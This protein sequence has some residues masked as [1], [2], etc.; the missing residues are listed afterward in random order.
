MGMDAGITVVFLD[1][2][3]SKIY[4]EHVDCYQCRASGDTFS[5]PSRTDKVKV[6]FSTEYE[7]YSDSD[8]SDSDDE[9]FTTLDMSQIYTIC[10][11]E[12]ENNADK[13][14]YW[15]Q[16]ECK[17]MDWCNLLDEESKRLDKE[18]SEEK[19]FM[20]K[21]DAFED[22]VYDNYDEEPAPKPFLEYLEFRMKKRDEDDTHEFNYEP[23]CKIIME[24]FK[25]AS[26]QQQKNKKI[27]IE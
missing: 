8:I 21:I 26:Q 7:H 6:Y 20:K 14:A 3:G 15:Q 5:V 16:L 2:N 12:I 10:R 22:D 25:K 24:T 4:K 1:G 17:A 11:A 13:L 18:C 23:L 27:K 9:L 19:Q